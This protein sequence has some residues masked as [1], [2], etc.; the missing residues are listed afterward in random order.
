MQSGYAGSKYNR[1]LAAFE[2][3]KFLFK[4]YL[5]MPLVPRVHK[6]VWARPVHRGRIF[7]QEIRVS[8]YQRSANSTSSGVGY[9]TTMNCEC[10]RRKCGQILFVRTHVYFLQSYFL[11]GVI[12]SEGE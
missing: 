12:D 6:A 2:C 3:S 5:V 8:H 1:S 7:R 9:V 4:A 10:S 11:L